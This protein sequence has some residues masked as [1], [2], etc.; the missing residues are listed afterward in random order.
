MFDLL[1]SGGAVVDGTGAPAFRA[2]LGISGKRIAAVGDLSAAA[3]GRV[4]DATGL[5]VCPGFIDTHCHTEGA[6]LNDPQHPSAIRMGVTTEVLGQD[7]MSYAPLSPENYRMYSRFISGL[8]SMPPQDLDMSSIAALRSHFHQKCSVNTVALVPHCAIRLSSVGFRDVPLTGEGLETAKRIV[9]EGIEQGAAGIASGLGFFPA[10][11]ADTEELIELG[12][13]VADMD[14]VFVIQNRSFNFD[15]AFGG[16][17]VAEFLEIG[18]RSG[19]KMHMAHYFVRLTGAGDASGMA[20]DQRSIEEQVAALMK[21]IDAAKEEGVDFTADAYPYPSGSTMP[22]SRLPG[23]F[24]EGGTE[25]V[26]ERLRDAG[27]RAKLIAY[28]DERHGPTMGDNVWSYIGSEQ[29]R[30]L[31]G[32][33]W[34]DAAARRGESVPEMMC[35]V[36][37]EEEL[38]CGLLVAPPRSVRLWRL[39]E[40]GMVA[41]LDRDDYMVCSDTIPIGSSPHPRAFGTFPRLLGRLRRRYGLRLEHLVQRMTQNPAQRF[42]LE[43]RGVLREGSYADIVVFDADRI[44]DTATYEDPWSYPVGMPYVVVNGK[45]AV[46]EERCTGELAGEAVP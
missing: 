42:G 12:K 34:R 23:W 3:A 6:L 17:A 28:L 38:D 7:G 19:A 5:T 18:R 36:M 4:I 22:V 43:G 1:I 31:E 24:C 46:D 9:R 10:A 2:D 13:V 20:P 16:D 32:M 27:Q 30:W 41:L 35:A 11:Y 29:N 37:L 15:R 26:L 8:Y 25:A 44:N 39:M 33:S 40:E 21:D 45:M 14:A